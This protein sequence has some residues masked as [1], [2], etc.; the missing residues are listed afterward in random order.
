MCGI[1]GILN[2]RDRAPVEPGDLQA[3]MEALRHRGPD[4]SGWWA[5]G[6][7][8][9]GQRRL[10]IID[11]SAAGRQPMSNEDESVW[12]T[13]NG[14]FYNFADFA[15]ELKRLGHVFR[16]QTDTELILHLY[17]QHGLDETLRR[18]NG[19]FAFGLWDRRRQVGYL[20]RDR[21]GIKPL[22]YYHD[23]ARL[24]FASEIKAFYRLP[25]FRPAVREDKLPEL[26]LYSEALDNAT[27]LQ[28]VYR[29]RP[30]TYMEIK[31]GR[32]REVAYY[33]LGRVTPNPRITEAEALDEFDR[34]L[35]LS[36]RRQ[37]VSDVPLGVFLS[38]GIDSSILA[39][40]TAELVDEPITTISV[41]YPEKSA[42]EFMWSDQ[43]AARIRSRHLKYTVDAG[44]FFELY[45]WITYMYDG[46]ATT[47]A[48]FFRAAQAARQHCTVMLCG[49]G[50]DEIF[51]GYSRYGH[52]GR[53][54]RLNRLA[55][56]CL[57]GAWIRAL[58]NTLPRWGHH[59]ALRKVAAR[60]DL[61]AVETA[62]AYAGSLAREDFC[63]V[64]NG[65]DP[66]SYRDLLGRYAA[67]FPERPDL[68]FVNRMLQAEMGSGLQRILQQTDRMT[69]AASVETRVPF[70]DH[71]LVEFVFSLPTRLKV[72]GGDSKVLP[73]KYLL[74]YFPREFVYRPKMGFPTPVFDWFMDP[75]NPIHAFLTRAGRSEMARRF[76]LD[77][78]ERFIDLARGGALGQSDDVLDPLLGYLSHAV[79]WDVVQSACA[80]APPPEPAG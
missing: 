78:V 11:L 36:I 46:P 1:C 77:Y 48:A 26:F 25:G 65:V 72:R 32:L 9:L 31:E 67:V 37:L 68:D 14:E 58:S 20:V 45:P 74:R 3:M 35:G 33:D 51:G 38:G 59:K 60:L 49:Q 23:G 7:V 54:H 2:L 55:A 64:L 27:L 56:A 47:G 18:M 22:Y 57:P 24:A 29:V 4:D 15:G 30:G 62:A 75:G 16:S 12:L 80:G 71:E 5:E 69:M 19:M 63:R 53:Q 66:G 79:W 42:N 34:L 41:A 28:N 61:D 43:V 73:K 70:L 40:K 8:G 39:I 50:S 21:F 10:S 17:E 6:P 44:N 13:Y 76:N 52:A